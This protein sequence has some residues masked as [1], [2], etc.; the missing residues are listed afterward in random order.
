M[1]NFACLVDSDDLSGM[2]PEVDYAAWYTPKEAKEAICH[3]SLAERF[4]VH[5]LDKR[6]EYALAHESYHF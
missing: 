5:W 3:D 6:E 4:L 2:T 1:L